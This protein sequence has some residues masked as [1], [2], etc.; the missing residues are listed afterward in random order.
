MS[1]LFSTFNIAKRGMFVQQKAIDVTTHNIANANT[2]GYSRQRAIIETTRPFGMPSMNNV[3]EP[4]QLGT[5]SEVKAIQR[6][7]DS[8]LDYQTRLET[9]TNGRY[10]ARDK[11]LGEIENI[12]NEPTDTGIS[13]LIGKFFDSWQQLSKQANNSNARTVVTQQSAALANELN[14]TYKEIQ[15]LKG[16]TQ[17]AIRDTVF[18]MNNMLS[19][20]DQLNQQ[21]I[22]VK[23]A[24]NQPNDLMD[25]RDLL[26]D[27]LSAKFNITI[28]KKEFEGCDVKP[29][30]ADGMSTDAALLVRSK[31]NQ[32]ISSFSYVSDI[33]AIGAGTTDANGNTTT[34]Y[35]VTYL[36]KGNGVDGTKAVKITLNNV[37]AADYKELDE[38]RVI[39]AKNDATSVD[40]DGKAIDGNGAILTG[41]LDY[42][43]TSKLKLYKPTSGELK[44]YMSVQEDQD[45]YMD[46]LN[47]LAKAIA[48]SVNAVHSGQTDSAK[49]GEPFFVNGAA[50]ADL[51]VY[52]TNNNLDPTKLSALLAKESEITAENISIN[53]ELLYH[54]DR[55]NAGESK[56]SGETD[57]S[58][59][60]AIAQVRD[61]MLNVAFINGNDPTSAIISRSDMFNA[62]KGGSVLRNGN[63]LV[64]S[65]IG[66]KIDNYFKDIVDR[67]GIQE[68]EAKRM[69]QNQATLLA[70]FQESK[71]SISGVSLDE[72]MANM[73]QYQHAYQANAKIIATV[74]EL[75]DVVVN[76]LKK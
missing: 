49:D 73:V 66:T 29:T 17:D 25:K 32:N 74:D 20:V 58:R 4:G 72:E 2:E 6:V 53:T 65:P 1:G 35:E 75:L 60:L 43:G 16:N 11:F 31:L 48:F 63:E 71:D 42:S 40:N 21:I 28:D 33:K 3:A 13:T 68:Q 18:D 45:A 9:S 39:W 26:L 15:K 5:G 12:L 14:H 69:V 10:E 51:K 24:G 27:Q 7:R 36:K 23:V 46:Q 64:S 30:D 70:G 54:N 52:D 57:G 59:A 34:N 61:K 44:G 38:C 37:T 47:R 56:T 67:L 41:P 22:G 8:Y 19:Q 76:G 62:A 55:I 50:A